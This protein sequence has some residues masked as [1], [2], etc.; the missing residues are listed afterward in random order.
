MVRDVMI[1]SSVLIV[2]MLMIRQL[3]KGRLNPILQYVL[4]IPVVLRLVMPLPLWSSHFSILNLVPNVSFGSGAVQNERIASGIS[5]AEEGQ[6]TVINVQTDTEHKNDEGTVR[7]ENV[8]LSAQ[9]GME[10]SFAQDAAETVQDNR[11]SGETQERMQGRKV[12]LSERFPSLTGLVISIWVVGMLSVGSYMLFYQIKWKKYLRMNRKPLAGREKYRDTLSVYTVKNLPSPC[13]SGKCIYLTE[14]MAKDEKRL[15]HILVHEYC[16]YRHLDFLWVFVRCALVVVY[17]FHPLVWTAARASKQDSELACDAAAI[18]LLGE[19]ERLAYGKTLLA[20]TAYNGCDWRRMGI[21]SAMSGGEKG[22]KDRITRIAGKP[23]YVAATAGIAILLAAA[24]VLA[25]FSGAVKENPEV[26]GIASEGQETPETENRQRTELQ[27]QQQTPG[28]QE[29]ELQQLQQQEVQEL[30]QQE[31]ELQKLQ[32]QIQQQE[33]EVLKLKQEMKAEI[34][35]SEVLKKLDSYGASIEETGSRT[36]VYAV[37]GALNI[38]EY[39]Q[40][41]YEKG[42][43]A[44]EE[45]MYLL[46]VRKGSDSSDIKIYGMYSREYGCEGV[47]ILIGN[48]AVD[49]DVVW[50]MSFFNGREENIRLYESAEDGMPRTFAWQ[51]LAENTSDAEV[52]NMFLCDRWDTGT[53]EQYEIRSEEFMEELG[54]RMRFEIHAEEC[55]I[56]VYDREKM[57]GSIS[58]DASPEAMGSIQKVIL[59]DSI[60]AWELGNSEEE[61]RMITAVGLKLNGTEEIWYYRLPLLRFPVTCGTFGERTFRLGQA[62][63]DTNYVNGKGWG[64]AETL[65]AFLKRTKEEVSAQGTGTGTRQDETD[66]LSQAFTD[67][68]NAHYDVEILYINPCPSYTRISDTF[69][70]R[71]N[72]STG[73]KRLHGGIDLAAEEG[74]DIVAAAEGTVYQTGFDATYGNYV[75]LYHVL[76]G[77]FTYYAGCQDVLAAEGDSVAAGQKIAT[78]GSTGRSAGPHLHFARSRNGEYVEPGFE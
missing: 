38:S 4:W 46:E 26:E 23:R 67:D 6:T 27:E 51:V 9:N 2:T 1:T 76:N 17:W 21:A 14:E 64:G 49:F 75:V 48:D 28:Q 25:T 11:I 73:E 44:L 20:L 65:D 36:G 58:V 70:A 33:Q 78:V 54:E 45:G 74:A 31:Q 18:R 77:E 10:N 8:I 19:Q 69:G 39:M 42:E 61:I 72:P 16:H 47:K 71:T 43:A 66:V 59:D 34:R 41:Y 5:G 15:E 56:D 55:R 35:E 29:Q 32:Q 3:A 37:R 63:V 60:I 62:S 68:G 24:A 22:I 52:W 57:V 50:R 40:D 13:L 7:T 30:R 12:A 53:I